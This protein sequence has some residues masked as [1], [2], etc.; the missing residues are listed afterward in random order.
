MEGNFMP[1]KE[2]LAEKTWFIS[3]PP[4]TDSDSD[5]NSQ[6]SELLEG[7][8]NDLSIVRIDRI[9]I[10]SSKGWKATYRE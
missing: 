4:E 7:E 2:K 6:L 9:E 1:A 3:D 5:K 10:G 8:W